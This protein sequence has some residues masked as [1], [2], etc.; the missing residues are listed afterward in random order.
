MRGESLSDT[1]D[2]WPRLEQHVLVYGGSQWS[3]DQIPGVKI[4]KQINK[5]SVL[6]RDRAQWSI[7]KLSFHAIRPYHD[8][9]TKRVYCCPSTKVHFI[10]TAVT[11]LFIIPHS[12]PG[13]VTKRVYCCPSTEVHFIFI[14]VTILFLIP[15]SSP[16]R[17]TKR[18]YCCPSTEVHFIFTAVTMLFIIS[19]SSPG[20]K[21]SS[22]ASDTLAMLY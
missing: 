6:S 3:S 21:Q 1:D 13:R 15:H 2:D 11:M 12:S 22:H 4:P 14:A 7:H 19:H 18:V 9:V 8:G 5:K 20:L 10:F 16:G 17:V